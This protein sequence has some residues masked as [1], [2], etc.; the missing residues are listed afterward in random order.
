[1]EANPCVSHGREVN[2]EY[3]GETVKLFLDMSVGIGGDKW[4]AAELFCSFICSTKWK[5]FFAQ[6]IHNSDCCELGSGN[7]IAG[8]LCSKI[9]SP[10]SMVITDM[11]SHVPHIVK[12]IGLNSYPEGA[13]VPIGEEL[14][15]LQQ[16]PP[17][18]KYDVLFA[19]EW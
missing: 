4:P 5:E 16:S 2:L 17:F 7:G 18:R 10:K 6:I 15:W 13:A 9:F 1:M 14:N 19:L 11:L 12:N 3:S 8:I